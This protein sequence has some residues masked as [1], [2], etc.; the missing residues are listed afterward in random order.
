MFSTALNENTFLIFF[1]C[2]YFDL[3]DMNLIENI[4]PK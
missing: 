3:N 1:K 2:Y 4:S